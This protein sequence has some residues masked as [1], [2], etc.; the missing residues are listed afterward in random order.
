MNYCKAVTQAKLYL[1]HS[2]SHSYLEW[3]CKR[4]HIALINLD[5]LIKAIRYN[6]VD[7]KLRK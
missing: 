6:Q 4:V 5:C 3:I 2:F 7:F 1:A